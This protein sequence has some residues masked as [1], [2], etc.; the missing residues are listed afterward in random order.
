MR[1]KNEKSALYCMQQCSCTVREWVL[2]Y[3]EHWWMKQDGIKT[4]FKEFP[5]SFNVQ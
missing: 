5:F 1:C 4:F 3:T 2:L